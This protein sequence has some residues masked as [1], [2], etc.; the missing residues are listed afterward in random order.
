[1]EMQES[2]VAKFS[3]SHFSPKDGQ[4]FVAKRLPFYNVKTWAG[5]ASE[6]IG[7]NSECVKNDRC[8]LEY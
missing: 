4:S 6:S 1:M 5:V 3:L 2:S 8:I 7:N